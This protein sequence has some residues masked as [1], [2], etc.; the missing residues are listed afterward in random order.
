MTNQKLLS[1]II[2]PASIEC[3]DDES[4]ASALRALAV[5]FHATGLSLRETAAV[6]ECFGVSRSYQAIWQWVHRHADSVRDPRR[7]RRRGSRLTRPLS[8]SAPSGAGCTR[9]S[10]SIRNCCSAC[11]SPSGGGRPPPLRSSGNSPDST[12]FQT[13]TFWLMASGT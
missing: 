1:E 2:E 6:L 12:T 9:R 11:A 7:R 5:R 10:T 13:P 8:R 3:W 4:T